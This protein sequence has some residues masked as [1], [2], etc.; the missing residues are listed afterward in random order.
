MYSLPILLVF[1]VSLNRVLVALY[2]GLGSPVFPGLRMHS[3]QECWLQH[4]FHL[5]AVVHPLMLHQVEQCGDAVTDMLALMALSGMT[6]FREGVARWEATVLFK[7]GEYGV[8][9]AGW[10]R[11]LR[12][13]PGREGMGWRPKLPALPRP[14]SVLL[15][16]AALC[17]QRGI[18]QGP[19]GSGQ[20]RHCRD[21]A[22][23]GSASLLLW[24]LAQPSPAQ[25]GPAQ[26]SPALCHPPALRKGAW[27]RTH[28]L[29]FLAFP[30][31]QYGARFP[32]TRL[33]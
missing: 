10:A 7:A 5:G 27:F 11:R 21:P 9:S 32:G 18:F 15:V 19:C 30:V 12:R 17:T 28:R 23:P 8:F 24:L 16:Q 22:S 2:D 20:R 26:P 6:S 33:G 3:G 29:Q 1:V 14:G 25:P 31:S 13:C 4:F